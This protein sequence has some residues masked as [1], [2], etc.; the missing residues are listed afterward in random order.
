MTGRRQLAP[1]LQVSEAL[2][3]LVQRLRESELRLRKPSPGWERGCRAQ[4]ERK[5]TGGA[6]LRGCGSKHW[7]RGRTRGRC[8]GSEKNWRDCSGAKGRAT[9]SLRATTLRDCGHRFFCWRERSAEKDQL[10]T[11]VFLRTLVVQQRRDHSQLHYPRA[12]LVRT[13][14]Q[15]VQQARAAALEVQRH[16]GQ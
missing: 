11:V 6:K 5:G 13:E 3:L 2:F 14:R 1:R 15:L 8:S 4:R 9:S 10:D 7:E 16:E 12:Q